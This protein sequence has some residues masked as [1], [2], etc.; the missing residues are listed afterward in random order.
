[1]TTIDSQPQPLRQLAEDNAYLRKEIT[2]LQ[3]RIRSLELRNTQ[4]EHRLYEKEMRLSQVSARDS[5]TATPHSD[6][7]YGRS[8]PLLDRRHEFCYQP[9]SSQ[10]S[11]RLHQRTAEVS[12]PQ[13]QTSLPAMTPAQFLW[14]P[15][16]R[17]PRPS[18]HQKPNTITLHV[19]RPPARRAGTAGLPVHRTSCSLVHHHLPSVCIPT[20]FASIALSTIIL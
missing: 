2:H 7:P 20:T 9:I 16:P 5:A 17:L 6:N 3:D 13:S 11:V 8:F 19:K 18:R 15:S 10:Q 12:A 14:S 4:L 1:M